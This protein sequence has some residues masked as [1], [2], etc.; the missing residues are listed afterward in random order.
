MGFPGFDLVASGVRSIADDVGDA[1]SDFVNSASAVTRLG[2]QGIGLTTDTDPLGWARDRQVQQDGNA[3]RDDLYAERE[4]E[5]REFGGHYD[6]PVQ[7]VMEN[8]DGMSHPAI[9]AAIDSTQ[10]ATMIQDAEA[11]TKTADT[12]KVSV[13]EFNGRIASVISGGWEG[14]AATR[15]QAAVTQYSTATCQLESAARLIANKINEGQT[16]INQAKLR[17]PEPESGSVLGALRSSVFSLNPVGGVMEQFHK[18]EEGRQ[19]AA[20]I[21]KTEYAPVVMQASSQIPVL[22]PPFDPTSAGTPG[23]SPTTQS[24][25]GGG[26]TTASWNTP[27]TG[28]ATTGF[29]NNGIGTGSPTGTDASQTNP[30]AVSP[31]SFDPS[32]GQTNPANTSTGA[33]GSGATS[34]ANPVATSSDAAT[35]AASAGG[36]TG[37]GASGILGPGLGSARAGGAGAAA[38]GSAG[39][40]GLATP[41]ALGAGVAGAGAGGNAASGVAAAG[42]P[43]AP[44]MG[45]MAPHGSRGRGETDTEHK[46]PDYL[47]NVDNAN[48]L[49][50]EMPKVAPPVIGG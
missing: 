36:G 29:G 6:A 9:K 46:T 39:G 21:M 5:Q 41:G 27:G 42:R 25:Y 37:A 35:R 23:N 43:G 44:G 31:A 19:E 13:A 30:S 48:D 40:A 14:T 20:Q 18:S 24:G 4:R 38:G 45:G 7:M 17:M 50:G 16:G 1:T 49:I 26:G 11:W 12:L 22:P 8:F 2:L 33:D 32:A 15:A 47:V 3:R 10:P 34:T 28:G